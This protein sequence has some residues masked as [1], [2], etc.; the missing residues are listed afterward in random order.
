MGHKN[1]H[2]YSENKKN[3]ESIPV[4]VEEL[5]PLASEAEETVTEVFENVIDEAI[6][7]ETVIV[8]EVKGYLTNCSKLNV[9]SKADKNAAVLCILSDDA[10]VIIDLENSTN[11]F[12]KVCTSAGVEGYCMKNFIAIK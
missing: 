6:N 9:R 5:N 7:D 12:Y 3:S 2:K 11:E 4:P 1:Y 10:E 8:E